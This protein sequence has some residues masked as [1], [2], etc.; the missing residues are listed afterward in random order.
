MTINQGDY[1][2]LL[3]YYTK[4]KTELEEWKN[5]RIETWA[6]RKKKKLKEKKRWNRRM[7]YNKNEHE[8]VNLI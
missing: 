3:M 1:N 5:E 4:L 6:R 7:K 2:E 8:K